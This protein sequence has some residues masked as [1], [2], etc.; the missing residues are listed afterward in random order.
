MIAVPVQPNPWR[1]TS[2]RSSYENPW[3]RVHHDEVVGPDG[4]PGIYGVVHF[5]FRA[6]GVVALDEDR[7]LLVG[8]HRY[9]LDAHSWE[10]PAGGVPPDE[11]ALS[12]AKRELA[13]D[14]GLRASGWRELIAFTLPNSVTNA[15]GI[16][17]VATRLE[18]GPPTPRGP[19]S[20]SPGGCRW[21]ARWR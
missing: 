5:R 3:I 15:R 11:D 2:R 20:S 13:E 8:Q 14:T 17:Y 18:Q 9:P 1:R 4:L 7:V 12:G 6:V 19:R 16:V 10:I 21:I